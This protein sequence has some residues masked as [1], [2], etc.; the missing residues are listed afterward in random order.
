LTTGGSDY[1]GSYK[2]DI[3]LGTGK[4]GNVSV[5]AAWLERLRG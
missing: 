5:P 3:K 4:N 2:P 1:H